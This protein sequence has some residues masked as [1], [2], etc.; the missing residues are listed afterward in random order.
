MW[1]AIKKNC[2]HSSPI[3]INEFPLN[4]W[5]F[6]HCRDFHC[7]IDEYEFNIFLYVYK[8][9]PLFVGNIKKMSNEEASD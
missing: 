7:V 6:L 1:T 5:F 2:I 9:G 4:N 8:V 3:P